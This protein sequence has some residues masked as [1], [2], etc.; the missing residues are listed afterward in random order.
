MRPVDADVLTG[1]IEA[2]RDWIVKTT[3]RDYECLK[4][5]EIASRNGQ[6]GALHWVLELID[7]AVST[8]NCENC[9]RNANND[10][11]SPE[12]STRCPIQEHYGL[13]KDGYCHLFEERGAKAAL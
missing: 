6:G 7:N 1:R 9:A 13:P 4:I 10:E 5:E 12:D 11:L 8:T 3:A 2:V